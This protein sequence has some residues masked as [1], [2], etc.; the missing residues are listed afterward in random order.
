[1][2]L[3]LP[4]W[5]KGT[6]CLRTF[7]FANF[8]W[9]GKKKNKNQ[10]YMR[11]KRESDLN[12]DMLVFHARNGESTPDKGTTTHGK[13]W[14]RL[15][16]ASANGGQ[17]N[18]NQTPVLLCSAS[19]FATLISASRTSALSSQVY[20]SSSSWRKLE[21]PV[22]S[23]T[24]RVASLH[25]RSMKPGIFK[26]VAKKEKL[27]YYNLRSPTQSSNPLYHKATKHLY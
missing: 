15:R 12:A 10:C 14:R 26:S 11:T 7:T 4:R 8:T 9:W 13:H 17:R 6:V 2:Q 22:V 1:M 21:V 19:S 3:L 24:F 27:F 18:A 23:D 25:N 20:H 5:A 16:C